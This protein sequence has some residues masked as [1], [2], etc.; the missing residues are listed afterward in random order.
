MRNHFLSNYDIKTLR[1]QTRNFAEFKSIRQEVN[2]SNN[3]TNLS[4]IAVDVRKHLHNNRSEELTKQLRIKRSRNARSSRIKDRGARM[5]HISP[6]QLPSLYY[7]QRQ[8]YNRNISKISRRRFVPSSPSI[9]NSKSTYLFA[10][11]IRKIS[12]WNV[13]V[14]K[15]KG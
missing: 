13:A 1:L 15:M 7:K 4:Y 11:Q 6:E 8:H 14:S 2:K 10:E 3:T 12:V 5:T 9:R